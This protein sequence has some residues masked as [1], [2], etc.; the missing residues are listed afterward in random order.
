MRCA[1]IC[2]LSTAALWGQSGSVRTPLGLTRDARPI[3]ALLPPGWSDVT[4][5]KARILL[6]AG[7][8]GPSAAS[9]LVEDELAWFSNSS[10]RAAYTIAAVALANPGGTSWP[11]FPP[12]GDAYQKRHGR[13]AHY[14]WRWIG[15]QA[16]DL[17]VEIR[18]GP[19]QGWEAVASLKKLLPFTRPLDDPGELV[20][21]LPAAAPAEVGTIPALRATVRGPGGLAALLR[22]LRR[23]RFQAPSPARAELR[24]RE[25]L[26]PAEVARQLAAVYG[27]ELPDAVYIPAVALI[28]RLRL[29]AQADVERIV[30]PYVSGERRALPER[31]TG[32]HLSGHL[33]FAELARRTSNPR[34]A[35]LVR[36]AADL[37]FDG[38]GQPLE[39]MP[40]HLEMSDAVFMGGPVLAAAG[41][42][43][44]ER[45][46]FD[47]CVR[48]IQFML[49]LTRRADGLH[50][51]SPLD[52]AAWGRGNAF[53]LLGLA[54]SLRDLPAD[55]PGT[56]PLLAAYRELAAS[57]L[58]HQDGSGL[59]RQ[60]VDVPGS[61]PELSATSMIAVALLHGMRGGWIG[62][63]E[64]Q[65]AVGRAWAGVRRR[66]GPEGRLVDVC[67]GTGKQTSLDE[68]LERTAILGTDPRGGAMA[69]LFATELQAQ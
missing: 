24:R 12:P 46:Y 19:Q 54:L 16:P 18:T 17:V 31:V 11:Q 14:L 13:E 27:H 63:D 37:G 5:E 44:G 33:V 25:A 43:T 23:A 41:A 55:H 9:R 38:S 36:A 30:A 64:Y 29:G 22:E 60:V 50:R 40:A 32:S 6:V 68:Y 10:E 51:H 34:Y 61:Y 39:A 57:L 49:K 53:V 28:G 7:L 58:R 20:A 48:H 47:Q 42:L 65:P 4:S 45:R 8:D 67:T 62:V 56:G 2:L 52:E 1:L 21:A 35:E 26:S 3:E 59:W 66:I 69:L 15:L